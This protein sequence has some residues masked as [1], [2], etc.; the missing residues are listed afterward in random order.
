VAAGSSKTALAENA[1]MPTTIELTSQL[2]SGSRVWNGYTGN[3]MGQESWS[4]A[5]LEQRLTQLKKLGYTTVAIPKEVSPF[6]SIRVDG[7]TGGRKAFRGTK[8]F[9]NPDV[10]T[11]TARFREKAAKLGFEI[12]TTEP[13]AASVLPKNDFRD[14]KALSDLVTPMCGEGVAERLWLG[15]QAIDKAGQLIAQN[16]SQLGVPTPDM[17]LRHLNAKG[18]PP[19]WL[20]EVKTLYTTAMNEM[21]R[22]NT[23]ARE[24]SRSF[25]LYNAKRLEFTFHFISAIESLYKSH[26]PTNRSESL[27]A[28]IES[29]YNSLNSYSDVAR[30]SS[31]RGTI[32]LLNEYGYRALRKVIQGGK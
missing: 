1:A 21:Y 18:T 3:A 17:L 20:T 12:V 5:D 32:A 24:G 7:D 11:I 31:D 4:E 26:E 27:E 13:V 15:F 25:T 19:A 30:D 8:I 2:V 10:V 16:D 22:A 14:E 28:A 9:E 29:V 6:T 23:R